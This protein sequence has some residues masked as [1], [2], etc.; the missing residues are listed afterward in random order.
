MPKVINYNFHGLKDC[1]LLWPDAAEA[2]PRT[3]LMEHYETRARGLRRM[4]LLCGVPLTSKFY[5]FLL[6]HLSMP[7]LQPQVLLIRFGLLPLLVEYLR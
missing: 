7:R 2:G 6:I 3:A 1:S 4:C 5:P